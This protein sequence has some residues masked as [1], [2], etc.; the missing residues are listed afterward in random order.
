MGALNGNVAQLYM[1]GWLFERTSDVICRSS[2]EDTSG[3]S[4]CWI[5]EPIIV[6]TCHDQLHVMADS[7][8]EILI[9]SV[10]CV[11]KTYLD[12]LVVGCWSP[13]SLELVM[14][15]YM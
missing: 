1:H 6:G 4:G 5:L 10:G 3:C 15:N 11:V 12:V 8:M 13:S 14:A 2:D 7:L 9:S